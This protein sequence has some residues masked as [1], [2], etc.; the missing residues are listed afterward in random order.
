MKK[1]TLKSL[2]VDVINF[3]LHNNKANIDEICN[4]FEVS[5][6]NIRTVLAKIEEFVFEQ[7]MGNLLKKSGYYYF[8]NNSVNFNLNLN[9][10]NISIELLEKK[11]RIVYLI[12]KLILEKSINLTSISKELN[13]SRITLNSDIESIK[14][15]VEKFGLTLVSIQWKGVFLKGDLQNLQKFSILFFSK[16]YIEN[17]FSSPLKKIINP[18]IYSYYRKYID[19]NI[20]TNIFRITDKIHQHFDIKL[21]NY[22]Y[23]ILI[24]LLIYIHLNYNE[25]IKIYKNIDSFSIGL[26]NT[27]SDILETDEKV[28]LNN[29]FDSIAIYLS[30]CINNVYSIPLPIK[31]NDIIAEIYSSFA[32]EKTSLATELL[33]F[34]ISDIYYENTL[35]IPNYTKFDKKEENLLN[36]KISQRLISIFNK[37]KITFSR[38]NIIFLYYYLNNLIM[39]AKKKNILIIDQSITMWKGNKLKEKLCHLEQVKKIQVLSYFNFKAFPIETYSKYDIFVFIDLPEEKNTIYRKK[40][41]FINGFEI[42]KNSINV[43][44]LF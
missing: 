40:V 15:I 31:T 16:L 37:Y 32:L 36:E 21:G 30:H 42:L 38:K 6:V 17:Y 10:N 44:K 7:K 13:V 8:E 25:E 20:E 29:N 19:V 23:F 18:V 43:S 35:F 3:I 2:D 14:E 24:S 27:L 22:H 11:E 33:G 41:Y 5:Q 4:C 26:K 12:L 9:S 28:L 1:T 39:E 34:F